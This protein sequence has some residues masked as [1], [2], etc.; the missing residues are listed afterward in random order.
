MAMSAEE[1]VKE[2]GL[3]IPPPFK[4]AG[5]YLNAVRSGNILF[6]AGHV[7]YRADGAII[8]G[9]LG[10]DMDVN[11]GYDAARLA[12]LGALATLRQELASLNSVERVLRVYGVVNST[13]DF[14]LHTRVIDGASDLFVEVFGEAGRH[15]RL[16]VGASSLP[17]GLALEI[18]VVVEVG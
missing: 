4:P 3:E 8:R 15:A 10:D 2:L 14:M 9:R 17:A 12:A 7:P 18:E 16:A 5:Q 13:P 1:R 11:S 6:L